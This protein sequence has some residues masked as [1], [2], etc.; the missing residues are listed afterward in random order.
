[1]PVCSIE[2][3]L[4]DDLSR[5]EKMKTRKLLAIELMKELTINEKQYDAAT[6]IQAVVRAYII[7]KRHS[8]KTLNVG[9][10]SYFW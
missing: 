7:R 2:E 3:F 9:I 6:T 4:E 10:F 8:L 1:M 5:L